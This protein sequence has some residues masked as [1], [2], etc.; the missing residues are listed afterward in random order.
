M[1]ILLLIVLTLG[2]AGLFYWMWPE[3]R[4]YLKIRSM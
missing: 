1:K 3:L 4:R 2:I